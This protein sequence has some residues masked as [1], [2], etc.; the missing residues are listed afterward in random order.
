MALVTY[1]TRSIVFILD[2]KIPNELEKFL[3]YV[4]F[5]ILSTLIFPSLLISDG[6]LFLTMANHHL[7]VGIITIAIAV[8]IR[9][10]VVAVVC[11]MCIMLTIKFLLHNGFNFVI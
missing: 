4:P 7:L 11:G 1:F 8:I 5:A 9:K 3:G 2:I 6:E 10:P